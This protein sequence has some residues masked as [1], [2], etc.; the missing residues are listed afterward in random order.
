VKK[1]IFAVLLV[2][3]FVSVALAADSN[4]AARPD[5]IPGSPMPSHSFVH[6]KAMLAAKNLVITSDPVDG[7]VN[8]YD[9]T[10]KQLAQ[11]TGFSQPQG[12]AT[13]AKGN[14]YVVDTNNSRILVYAPPYT[15]TPTTLSD[16]G[17]YPAGVAVY[18]KGKTTW[19]AV[20]NICSAPNCTQGG[21]IVYKNGKSKGAF[22]S[23]SIYRVYFC[24]FDAKGNLYVDGEN[25]SAG[26]VVGEIP[27]AIKNKQTFNVLTTGNSI[28]FPGGVQVT[29]KGKIAIDD[30]TGLAVYTY[31]PPKNGSLGSPI[32]TT[33]LSGLSDPVEFALTKNN[34][35]LWTGDYPNSTANEF[36]YPAGGSAVTSWSATYALGIAV[37]PADKP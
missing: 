29:S 13:D 37:V 36:A 18:S 24:D 17:Y 3:C 8:I 20:T 21:F 4:S 1:T 32:A 5:V 33:P 2:A 28:S 23:S 14:L 16:S 34:K 19:V 25:S 27:N 15:K 22:Q 35:D 7:N 26:I 6:V 10:G 31:N 9:P 30:Q 11:L 12:L